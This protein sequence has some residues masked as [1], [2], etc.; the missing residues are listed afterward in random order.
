[1]FPST[2]NALCVRYNSFPAKPG[3][4]GIDAFAQSW[5]TRCQW[6]NPPFAH[7]EPVLAKIMADAATVTL[8]LPVSQTQPL[9]A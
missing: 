1:M 4:D 2:V 9:W 7:I 8:V 5:A 6:A 3:C